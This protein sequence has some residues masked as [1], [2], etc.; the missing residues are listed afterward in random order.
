MLGLEVGHMLETTGGR[1]HASHVWAW[2]VDWPE[3]LTLRPF[4]VCR[5]CFMKI[6]RVVLHL[7]LLGESC[8]GASQA[9]T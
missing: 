9:E 7:V 2:A 3:P 4:Q 8:L 5:V 1:V 6:G